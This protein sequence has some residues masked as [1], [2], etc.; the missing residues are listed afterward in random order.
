VL[1][2]M[3]SSEAA[4]AT[5]VERKGLAQISDSGELE[6]V[7]ARVVAAN[8]DLADKFRGGKRGVLGAMVGQVMRETRG[9]ANP[10]LVSDLLEREIEE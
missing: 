10:K 9:R 3:F 1:A 6:A 7:V 5:I 2:E 4:P 8:P